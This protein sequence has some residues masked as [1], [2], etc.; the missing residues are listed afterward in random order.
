MA[1]PHGTP[2]REAHLPTSQG[3]GNESE[4]QEVSW[5]SEV[6]SISHLDRMEH[7]S[8]EGVAGAVCLSNYKLGLGA[9]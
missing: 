6:P 8:W 3:S 2:L 4:G 1:R 5:D 7:R 9:R